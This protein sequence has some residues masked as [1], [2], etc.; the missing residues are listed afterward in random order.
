MK[1]MIIGLLLLVVGCARTVPP[2][3][4]SALLPEIDVVQVKENSDEALRLAQ[5]AKVDVEALN[6]KVTVL[7]NNVEAL[8]EEMANISA[9]KIEELENRL[10]ILWE[11]VKDIKKLLENVVIQKKPKKMK[12]FKPSSAKR[13]KKLSV[14]AKKIDNTKGSIKGANHSAYQTALTTFNS[15]SYSKSIKQFKKLLASDKNGIY[16]D[17]CCY[18]IGECYYMIN[19]YAQAIGW[20]NKV[21]NYTDTEKADD[22][23][24][25]VAKSYF[26]LGETK[27]SVKEYKKLLS[28]YPSSEY[29][30]RAKTDLQKIK[31]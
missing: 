19:D 5:E 9:A 26:K 21:F 8:T 31:K 24:F 30:K 1:K 28:L 29:V 12:I 22:A 6:S 7:S 4:G 17:N 27:Q 18:W 16:A 20:Y 13:G 23:Q 14:K 25:K 11:E 2:P 10:A 15:R 3:E